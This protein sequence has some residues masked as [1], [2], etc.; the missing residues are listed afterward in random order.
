MSAAADPRPL[1]AHVVYRFAVGGLENGVVN[2]INHLPVERWR[3]AVVSLTDI[4]ATFARRITSPNVPLVALNKP[5]GQGLWHLSAW[6]KQL[7]QLRPAIVHTRNLAALELQ[8][9]AWAAGV[10]ARIHGEHGRDADDPHG[11]SRKHQLMRRCL[12]PFVHHWIA[13][14]QELA[15]Y[16][17]QKIGVSAAQLHV[18]Y[19]GVDTSRFRPSS[20]QRSLDGCPFLDPAFWL[21]GTV[22]R[23]QTVKAQPVLVRAFITALHQ[24]PQLRERVRLVLVGDGALRGECQAL[25]EAAGLADLA[26]VAGERTDVA[27]VMQAL[28]C[29]VLPSL[30]EGI[31]NTILEAMA[32]GLPVVATAVGANSELVLEGLTGRLV[33]PGDVEALATAIQAFAADP[34]VARTM[35][36]AGRQ[37]V[38]LRFSL[39]SMVSEYESVYCEALGRK[40]QTNVH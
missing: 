1:I 11:M 9:A 14:G 36:R 4:D 28:D 8:P 34:A 29:F 17:S 26:W 7:C 25:L 32:S 13:L 21:V 38:E 37:R 24:R 20:Q 18:I 10:R 27:D 40:E 31:S 33:P 19:N 3:H 6:R 23:M 35:G 16:T 22:G 5:P 39:S 30:A 12:K 15:T 2:L